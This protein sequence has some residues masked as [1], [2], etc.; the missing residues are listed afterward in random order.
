MT[1]PSLLRIVADFRRRLLA[2]EASAAQAMEA[3]HANTLKVIEVELSKLYDAM[4]EAI[5][6]GETFSLYKLY[7]ANR[8]ETIKRLISS[9]IDQFGALARTMTGRLQEDGVHMGLDAALQLLQ[10]QVPVGVSWAFGVP[11]QEAL[12]QL[13]GA[14]QAGSPL[15]TLFAGF[16]AEAADKAAKALISGVTLGQNPREFAPQVQGAL[17]VSKNRALVIS[18]QESLRC[19]RG[20]ALDTYR[21]NN[22]VV[23]QWRWTCAK[24]KRT[25]IACIVM[26]GK[27]FPLSRDFFGH[28]QCR[29]TPVPI[30][31]GW[32]DI[33]GPFG[34]DTSAIPDTR[35]NIEIGEAWFK[36]QGEAIQR[37]ILGDRRYDLWKDP[38][39]DISLK[40][41]V[42]LKHDKDWG[43][44]IKVRSL[45]DVLLKST[46][47]LE[48]EQKLTEQ[49]I[50]EAERKAKELAAKKEQ[51][52]AE[53]RAIEEKAAVATRKRPISLP[54][55]AQIL[56]AKMERFGRT[57]NETYKTTLGDGREY[58]VKKLSPYKARMEIAGAEA[59][60]AF[61]LADRLIPMR[62]G[63]LGNR[64]IIIQPWT[65]AKP[66]MDH[67]TKEVES[68]MA[69]LSNKEFTQ[70]HIW[71]YVSGNTD[72]N[73]GNFLREKSVKIKVIDQEFLGRHPDQSYTGIVPGY[74]QT[75]SLL[76]KYRALGLQQ[77]SPEKLELDKETL[78]DIASRKDAI[79][80]ALQSNGITGEKLQPFE[81]RLKVVEA[82]SKTA[83]KTTLTTLYRTAKK[84][85]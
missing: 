37:H 62:T 78:V 74:T 3:A 58:F 34:I 23:G 19:Y 25:C 57:L 83:G 33:L 15:A 59:G 2:N 80:E 73:A 27:T 52:L 11:S 48:A 39:N 40:S 81:N 72:M 49:Q 71:E 44:S 18:R 82:L 13:V 9:Q 84:K 38:S 56:D 36:R 55:D 5:A 21:A 4:T 54:T 26:D 43:S 12:A 42:G 8:L 77:Y 20:A 10:V 53:K 7:E 17:D 79:L 47:E 50:A 22:D 70:L 76:V 67:S 1:T 66:L 85:L 69:S 68:I 63:K 60:K 28:V 35:S 64:T 51:E 32:D 41:F 65:E 61:G 75:P 16:G 6:S 30:T 14:T 45:K 29:C 46:S 31:R 24:N